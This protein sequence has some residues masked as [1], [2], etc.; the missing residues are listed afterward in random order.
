MD[1]IVVRHAEP[2]RIPPG[3]A[4]ADPPLTELGRRQV[5]AVS[6]WLAEEP[7][8]AVY[9]SSLRRAVET[10][11]GIAARHGLTVEIEPDIREYDAGTNAYIPYEELKAARDPHWLALAEDRLEDLVPDGANF[12]KRVAAAM[13]RIIEANP[14]RRVVAVCHGGAINVWCAEV[15]KLDR[16]LWFE[17][18][19]ASISRIAASRNGPRSMVTLNETAHLRSVQ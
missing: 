16:D 11:E 9:A 5:E 10:A 3:D 13:E 18:A 15:L 17:P 6:A 4:P 2:E 12:R 14:G 7:I 8:D 19:Y 1:L